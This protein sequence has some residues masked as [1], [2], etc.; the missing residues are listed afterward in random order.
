MSNK[1][2]I[3]ALWCIFL[4]EGLTSGLKMENQEQAVLDASG[5]G[6]LELYSRLYNAAVL[7]Y[8][9]V[10]HEIEQLRSRP[11]IF[12]YDVLSILGQR[13]AQQILAKTAVA[14]VFSDSNVS[15]NFIELYQGFKSKQREM[16]AA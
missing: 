7:C 6:A 5:E 10:E 4:H 13:F 12:E 8:D 9:G 2:Q 15:N 11:P 14:A 3:I 16:Q 1:Q